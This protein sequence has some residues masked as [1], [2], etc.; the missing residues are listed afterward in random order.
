MR[1]I[2]VLFLSMLMD[3]LALRMPLKRVFSRFK[4]SLR[5][6]DPKTDVTPPAKAKSPFLD[7]FAAGDRKMVAAPTPTPLPSPIP[8]T[9]PVPSMPVAVDTKPVISTPSTSPAPAPAPGH[10]ISPPNLTQSPYLILIIS[11]LYHINAHPNPIIS[12]QP[13]S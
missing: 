3:C 6:D 1:L 9:T 4:T 13:S 7:L 2:L 12:N 8:A 10:L 11:N 5:S